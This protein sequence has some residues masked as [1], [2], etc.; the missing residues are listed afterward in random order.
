MA[1]RE[2]LE[3]TGNLWAASLELAKRRGLSAKELIG[4]E[5]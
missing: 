3:K 5:V 4:K 2:D 1:L